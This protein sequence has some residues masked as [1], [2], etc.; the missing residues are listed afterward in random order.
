[1][2]INNTKSSIFSA[3]YP[4]PATTI[5]NIPYNSNTNEPVDIKVYNFRGELL[6]E[7]THKN[8]SKEISINVEDLKKGAYIYIIESSE[9]KKTGKFIKG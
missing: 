8:H 1:M 4:I 6:K 9:A 5:I 2:S 3:P 7:T